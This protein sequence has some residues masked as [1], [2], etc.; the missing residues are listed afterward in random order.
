MKISQIL[1]TQAF[2]EDQTRDPRSD[3]Y[4]TGVLMAMEYK[5]SGDTGDIEN[6]YVIGT[7]DAD[8]WFAG[9]QEGY[10]RWRNYQETNCA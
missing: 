2:E 3:A 9:L 6:P 1:F 8:A 7:A 5:E 4:K 10:S